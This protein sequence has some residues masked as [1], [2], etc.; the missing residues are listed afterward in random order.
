M[1]KGDTMN[2]QIGNLCVTMTEGRSIQIG[3]NVTI[4]INKIQGEKQVRVLIQAPRD[5]KIVRSN[6]KVVDAKNDTKED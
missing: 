3:E 2:K 1:E 4:T 5:V 6:A